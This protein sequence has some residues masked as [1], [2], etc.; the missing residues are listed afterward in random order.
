MNIRELY[1][2]WLCS[3]VVDNHVRDRYEDLLRILH[4][5]CFIPILDMDVNRQCDGI[6]IRYRFSDEQCLMW[7]L[8]EKK[9]DIFETCSI[10][11]L[12]V[13]LSIR[14]EESIMCD[15]EYGDR[16]GEWF[17]SML[18]SLGLDTMNNENLSEPYVEHVIDRFNNREYEYN[19]KGGLFTV[20]HPPKDMRDT[21]IWY[22]MN[23]YLDEIIHHY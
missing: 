23:W 20:K 2:D 7:N 13:S 3:K 11:E 12:M 22:Q 10:L 15:P 19:G 14:C 6:D 9:L 21:E 5:K 17:W 18:V 4:H 8:I 1:F 16:T